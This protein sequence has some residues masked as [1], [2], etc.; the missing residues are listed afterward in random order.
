MSSEIVAA[1]QSLVNSNPSLVRPALNWEQ[2]I[3]YNLGETSGQDGFEKLLS[4]GRVSSIYDPIESLA[5]SLFEY[6]HP[7]DKNDYAKKEAFIADALNQ[8]DSFGR[9]VF[10]PWSGEVIRYL[11]ED[12]H[13]G[14]RTF[15][16][17]NLRTKEEQQTLRSCTIAN[18]GLSVGSRVM[19]TLVESGIGNHYLLADLDTLELSN[20]NRIQ[21][22]N[23]ELGSKK[24][25]NQARR[26]SELDPWIKQTH[27]L[28]GF[29]FGDVRI[30]EEI[31]PNII[32]EAVDDMVAKALL[33]LFAQREGVPLI[34]PADLDRKSMVDVERYD[35]ADKKKMLFQG[36]L[37]SQDIE[38][39]ASGNLTPGD[40]ERM[41]LKHT[42]IRNL[43]YRMMDSVM[44]R[45]TELGGMPQLGVTA[46]RGGVDAAFAAEEILLGRDMPSGRYYDMP[47][48]T[49]K[50]GS[51]VSALSYL[52]KAIELAK[53]AKNR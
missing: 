11:S 44:R 35:L 50:V 29:T 34:M 33:R 32:I 46:I 1:K 51:D 12:D 48:K 47:R 15:R 9:L 37:S 2:P 3:I 42:G 26:I 14:V 41:M 22:S 49:F 8:G 30:L 6:S 5:A 31:K 17:R 36:K 18:V 21:G 13:V 4:S 25:F 27:L 52:R 38:L 16:D 24:V 23:R 10:F 53:Y 20:L 28:D 7:A 43:S 39:M 19:S 45:D 40:K